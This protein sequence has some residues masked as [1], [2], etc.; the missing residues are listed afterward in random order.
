ML[1]LL[2]LSHI[3]EFNTSQ[4]WFSR[5]KDQLNIE[6]NY[7]LLWAIPSHV[8]QNHIHSFDSFRTTVTQAQTKMKLESVSYIY[9]FRRQ[10]F[11]STGGLIGEWHQSLLSQWWTGGLLTVA[12]WRCCHA[13]ERPFR[14]GSGSGAGS[15]RRELAKTSGRS[16]ISQKVT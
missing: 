15:R 14:V 7:N 8:E 4:V 12:H 6:D 9:H 1:T 13:E 16:T 3:A 11:H 10:I 5:A 2:L